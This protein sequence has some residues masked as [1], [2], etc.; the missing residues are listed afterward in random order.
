MLA[1]TTV[2]SS[3]TMLASCVGNCGLSGPPPPDS[4]LSMPPPPLPS[5]LL[6]K[7]SVMAASTNDSHPCFATFMC[8]PNPH[9]RESGME[10]VELIGS[11]DGGLEN[12]WIFVLITSCVGVLILGGLLAIILLKCRDCNISY[13]D[14]NIK[15]G[16]MSALGEPSK[17]NPFLAGGILYPCTSVNGRDTLQSQLAND[18]R[19][20]WA[21]LTPHGT[22]HFISDYPGFGT[23]EVTPGHY[24]VV[25]YRAKSQNQNFR[26]YVKRTP[27]K[28]FDNNGFT[29]YDY[30]DPTPLMD[31]YHD[32]MDSGYQEP[33]EVIGSI[34]RSSP[35]PHVSSPTRIDNPNIAPL[36]YY[37]INTRSQQINNNT[38][39]S[40]NTSTNSTL[41][42]PNNLNSTTLNR[43]S[44][45]SRRISDASSYN[46]Q[47]I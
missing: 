7:T 9:P 37:P 19:L 44:T 21:T 36:N 10:F 4:I 12:T 18:S 23:Q 33:Q 45:L 11:H 16:T 34:Q 5:F 24:E 20:L 42:R 43:K 41:Q 17:S 46:G 32:D 3:I 39:T 27:I 29:D 38:N 47:N 13:H 8:D 25:D 2:I 40:I 6:P 28:S 1:F 35:R 22:R 14:S 30:E 31:S 15:Q 26:D